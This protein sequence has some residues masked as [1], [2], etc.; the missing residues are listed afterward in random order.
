MP[1]L[2][3]LLRLASVPAFAI[4]LL[5]A[6]LLSRMAAMLRSLPSARRYTLASAPEPEH[7]GWCTG[8]AISATAL[9]AAG[10]QPGRT[11]QLQAVETA[12]ALR[13][14][15]DAIAATALSDHPRPRT[16]ETMA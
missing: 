3:A 2:P 15:V 11:A 14:R 7:I 9:R 13:D 6:G 10:D 4:Q 12:Q 8:L 1:L 16:T 5:D